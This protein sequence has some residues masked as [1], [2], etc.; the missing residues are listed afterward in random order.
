MNITGKTMIFR[1]EYEGK[2]IYSTN[3]SNKDINGEYTNMYI[4]IQLPKGTELENKTIIDITKGFLSFYNSKEGLPKIKIVVKEYNI[5]AEQ[6][7]AE[8]ERE[9]IQNENNYEMDSTDL[10]F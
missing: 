8:Q 5:D 7:Y 9:A 4:N 2:N 3:I 10:P 1:K 6:T